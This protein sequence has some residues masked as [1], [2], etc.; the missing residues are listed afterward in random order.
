MS[1]PLSIT[2]PHCAT[3]LKLKD[4][5]SVGKKVP[6]PKCKQPFVVEAPPEDEEDEFD[7]G[8][9]VSEAEDELDDEPPAP[10]ARRKP[11]AKRSS[12]GSSLPLIIGGSV[13]GVLLLAG[14][15]LYAAGVFSSA[16]KEATPVAAEPAESAEPEQKPEQKPAEPVV[17]AAAPAAPAKSSIPALT[18]GNNRIIDLAYLPPDADMFF[19][20]RVAD[21]WQAPLVQ[22]LVKT[23]LP[24]QTLASMEAEIGLSPADIESITFA[25]SASRIVID[26]MS[27]RV[28]AIAGRGP[29][30]SADPA[31]QDAK[32]LVTVRTRKPIDPASLKLTRPGVTVSEHAGKKYHLVAPQGVPVPVATD[33]IAVYLPSSTLAVVGAEPLIKAAIDRGEKVQARPELAFVDANAHLLFAF[34]PPDRKAVFGPL[35]NEPPTG[36]PRSEDF[37]RALQEHA[38]GISF[39]LRVGGGISLQGAISCTDAA[40][41]ERIREG[42]GAMIQEGKQSLA[43]SNL[44]L[45]PPL[46]GLADQLVSSLKATT[47][48]EVVKVTATIP[49]SAQA[50]LEALPAQLGPM[51]MMLMAAGNPAGAPGLSSLPPGADGP[52]KE[53]IATT[54][55]PEG[56]TLTARSRWNR[57]PGGSIA[58]GPAAPALEIAVEL[59]GGPAA[60]AVSYGKF[61]IDKIVA[62]NGQALTPHETLFEQGPAKKFLPRIND[63][64]LAGHPAGGIRAAFAFEPPAAP[65]A[66]ITEFSGS[67]TLQTAKES[68]TVTVKNIPPRLG[69]PIDHVEFKKAGVQFKLVKED[70][71]LALKIMKGEPEQVPSVVA[72]DKDGSPIE[73]LQM[74]LEKSAKDGRMQFQCEPKTPQLPKEMGLQIT[75]L[76]GISD[77]TVGFQ[78]A[79]LLVSP[80]PP[81]GEMAITATPGTPPGAPA[82]TPPGGLKGGFGRRNRQPV[83]VTVDQLLGEFESNPQEA[84]KKYADKTVEI[85]G[86]ISSVRRENQGMSVILAGNKAGAFVICAQFANDKLVEQ[87]AKIGNTVTIR[88]DHATGGKKF[89]ML[90]NCELQED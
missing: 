60:E 5:G 62:A 38:K 36:D 44:P 14:L 66:E 21:L 75:V 47:D 51:M 55:V 82:G 45:P 9:E 57:T 41:S 86:R 13:V 4:S 2:C 7:F 71:Y 26:A 59:T 16:K 90:T 70:A 37:K 34:I 81:P 84:E 58:G 49:D 42:L 64:P 80:A 63:D 48:G 56:M 30:A 74:V 40:G 43:Q 73:T 27:A 61:A 11:A 28:A 54:G 89:V 23:H 8:E 31:S 78:F 87:Q 25:G 35:K 83:R 52:P 39:G 77:I 53:P 67:L 6:C 3:R 79:D 18:A 29:P 19:V 65:L 85:V 32:T 1:T 22:S 50:Q 20:L 88:A 33:K 46:A 15:G 69:K 17:A 68:K 76:S 10:A 12:G 72:V 24:P